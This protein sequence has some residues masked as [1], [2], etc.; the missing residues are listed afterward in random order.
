M[1]K[2]VGRPSM[3]TQRLADRICRLLASGYS[4]RSI[5]KRKCFPSHETI[6]RWRENNAEFG[7]QYARA[8]EEQAETLVAEIISI[9]DDAQ[10]DYVEKEVNGK[11]VRVIDHEHI[12]RSRL[13]VDARKWYAS[14]VLP[15]IYGEKISQEHSGP[16]GAPIQI[17]HDDLSH[18][19]AEELRERLKLL[20]E[21]RDAGH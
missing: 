5:C 6:R 15:K 2:R 9:A 3:F 7:A 4:L 18:L 11:L 21:A 8:R 17:A 10:S 20:R 12:Q 13:R 16:G 19:S 1:R 14:K